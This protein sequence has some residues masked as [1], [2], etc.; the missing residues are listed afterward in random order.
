MHRD[1]KSD[2]ILAT[3]DGDIKLADFGFAV[4]LTKE[5]NK[6]NSKVGTV[7]WMAPEIV[8]GQDKYDNKVDIWSLGIFAMELAE[9][10]PPYFHLP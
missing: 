4:Q 5:S 3:Y 10:D 2:N 6:R 9:G 8:L 7:C 1:L